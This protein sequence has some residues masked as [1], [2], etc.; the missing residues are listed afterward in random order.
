MDKSLIFKGDTEVEKV[1]LQMTW[2]H[3]CVAVSCANNQISV[4]VNGVKI[5]ET[6]Q[7]T[8]KITCP[9]SLFGNL[10]LIKGLLTP[11][12]WAQNRGRV[13]NVNMF[14]GLMS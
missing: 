14:S 8:V 1:P 9:T 12:I 10:V 13:T 4:V 3:V 5:L 11:G 7:I 6:F 2:L